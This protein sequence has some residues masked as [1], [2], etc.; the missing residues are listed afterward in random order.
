MLESTL[1]DPFKSAVTLRTEVPKTFSPF[2]Y[3]IFS[4][5]KDECIKYAHIK[6]LTIYEK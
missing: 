5:T 2:V 1:S 3:S 6:G 4:G